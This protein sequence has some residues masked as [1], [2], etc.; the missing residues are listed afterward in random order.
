MISNLRDLGGMTAADG[1]KIRSGML[2]RSA[3]LTAAEPED[4]NGISAVIDLRTAREREERP[5]LFYDAEYLPIPVF[6]Q[7]TAGI[8]HEEE[9][10]ER[11]IPGMAGL[12]ALL[13]RDNA[14]Q[15]R[16]IVTAIMEH[17]FSTGAVLWHCSEGKDRCGM[18]TSLILEILGVSREDIM[19]DYMKTNI[20][21]LPKAERM[22][23]ELTASHG[24]EYAES[25][26]QAIIAD[27]AYLSAAWDAMETDYI[28]SRLGITEEEILRFRDTVLE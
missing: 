2:V 21:N 17:D 11:A 12:Y 4:L 10:S 20:V 23:E 28:G 22:K 9:A 26:Y 25:M 24:E 1:K 13:I 8:S 18:T 16:K 14:D 7:I 19:E 15:F 27:E 5:D 6:E 3:S